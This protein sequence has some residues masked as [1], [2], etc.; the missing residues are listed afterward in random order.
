MNSKMEITSEEIA[1]IA[2]QSV[3]VV[4]LTD[5]MLQLVAGGIVHPTQIVNGVTIGKCIF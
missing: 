2:E 5:D 4:E 1:Q 3:G